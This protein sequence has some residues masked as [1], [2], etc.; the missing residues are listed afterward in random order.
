MRSLILFFLVSF[1]SISCHKDEIVFIPDQTFS[2][3]SDELLSKLVE[4]PQSF[5]IILNNTRNIFVASDNIIIDIPEQSIQDESGQ[6]VTGEIKMQFKEFSHKKSNLLYG[7]SSIFQNKVLNYSKIFYI[8]FSQNGKT[9]QIVKPIDVYLP[10]LDN[11]LNYL[12]YNAK[13]IDETFVWSKVMGEFENVR[14]ESWNLSFQDSQFNGKG[15][16]VPV[17]GVTNWYSIASQPE[18]QSKVIDVCVNIPSSFSKNNSLVYLVINDS[19]SIIKL[20]ADGDSSTF[21]VLNILTNQKLDAKLI[22]ISHLGD[23]NYYFGMTNAVLDSNID[24]AINPVKKNIK[25][26]KEALN[27]L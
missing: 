18:Q 2:I 6:V 22:V 23:E 19:N 7:P 10:S 20:E 4:T 1:L 15:F 9:L 16:K 25:D 5:Q 3:N 8:K 26:I 11:N 21:C 17:S 14:N 13:K 12:M 24:V 27:S